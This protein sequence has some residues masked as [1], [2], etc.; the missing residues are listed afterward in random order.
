MLNGAALGRE[1][2]RTR[3]PETGS[4]SDSFT[5]IRCASPKWPSHGGE[6]KLQPVRHICE[7]FWSF[8]AGQSRAQWVGYVMAHGR[9][10]GMGGAAW[11]TLDIIRV[12]DGKMI[13]HWDVIQDEA[14]KATSKSGLYEP[15]PPRRKTAY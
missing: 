11:I 5:S 9:F 1:Y 4:T 15:D 7:L 6:I 12:E 8:V 14:T 13:E 2:W 10:S 3:S